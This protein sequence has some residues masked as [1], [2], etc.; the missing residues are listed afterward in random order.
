MVSPEREVSK[1]VATSKHRTDRPTKICRSMEFR[2]CNLVVGGL[3]VV[4]STFCTIVGVG[5]Y[6]IPAAGIAVT[7]SGVS[8]F[9]SATD[10]LFIWDI[11]C[12]V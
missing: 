7:G 2:A 9:V 1:S 6:I 4:M 8:T 11:L 3:F 12:G 10:V 5:V